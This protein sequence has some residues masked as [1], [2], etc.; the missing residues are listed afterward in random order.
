MLESYQRKHLKRI[1][2]GL[3]PVVF[4][5]QNGLSPEV[6]KHAREA[7]KRH[8]LIKIKFIAIKEKDPKKELG[9]MLAEQTGADI[10]G[11]IGHTLILFREHPDPNKRRIA[12]PCKTTDKGASF[13][14]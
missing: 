13:N 12:L 1:A 7:L 14:K 3:K 2:H 9:Q 11:S 4:I 8:E 6:V 5:G 10:V